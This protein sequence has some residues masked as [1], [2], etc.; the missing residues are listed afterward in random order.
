MFKPEVALKGQFT[1]KSKIHVF[2]LLCRVIIQSRQFLCE[3]SSFGEN[4]HRDY[5]VIGSVADTKS[6][7]IST[8]IFIGT[9]K[10]GSVHP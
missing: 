2:P 5:T 3:L 1:P 10:D 4:G 6:P 9:E 8:G 7:G